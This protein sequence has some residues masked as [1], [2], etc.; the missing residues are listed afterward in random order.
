MKP[1]DVVK[2][3]CHVVSM[4]L[5][6]CDLAKITSFSDLLFLRKLGEK[7]SDDTLDQME[8][9]QMINYAIYSHLDKLLLHLLNDLS[10]LALLLLANFLINQYTVN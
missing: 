5:G 2:L 9:L 1:P 4:L 8:N 10:P 3:F 7:Q 6:G